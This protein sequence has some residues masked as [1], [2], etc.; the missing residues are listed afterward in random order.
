MTDMWVP[1]GAAE[2]AQAIEAELPSGAAWPRDPSSDLMKWVSGCAGVWGDFDARAADFLTVES[3]P[4]STL[5]LL[6][7]WERAFGLPDT[8]V[9]SPQT[10]EERRDALVAR[11]TALGGQSRAFY[12]N[13]A[14]A[15]GYTIEIYEYAPYTC[16]LSYCGDTRPDGGLTFTYAH[17]GD[18][19]CGV[20]PICTIA[21]T[22]N[23]DW[24]WELGA[25]ELRYY[26]IVRV[27]DTRLTW[28][29][30]GT[31]E[32]G[33]DHLCEFADALDLEC[34]IRRW[35]PAHTV[36]IFDYSQ[37]DYTTPQTLDFSNP[38]NSGLLA[39]L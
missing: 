35:A 21:A 14:A 33:Q 27:L 2:Y 13:A 18:M 12:D 26:W 20:D 34:L 4:R 1:R 25:P 16:G 30:G 5:E 7:D 38:F 10:I 17:C 8:C 3:D 37:V 29:R 32:C 15:L 6:P 22:G 9:A 36:V 11:L 31:G 39:L 23:D 28:F 24:Y 19:Q